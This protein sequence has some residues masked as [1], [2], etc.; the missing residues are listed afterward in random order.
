MPKK[1]IRLIIFVILIT[2]SM[3]NIAYAQVPSKPL[4]YGPKISALQN[5]EDI[6]N[7]LEQLKTIRANLI[8]INVKADTPA[9]ELKAID[10]DL[11]RYIDQLRIIRGNLVN[12][13]DKYANS[14]SDVFFAEQIVIIANCY[15]VSL[16]HQQLLIRALQNNVTE[17]STLFY[18]TYMIPIYYYI[19][20]GDEQIAY[21]QTYIVVS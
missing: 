11:Q 18:S 5:K 8:V 2:V 14:I 10:T 9:E 17:A 6:L 20:L 13:A 12:H 16:K 21:T 7:N 19:T 4:P 15:I 3:S 1:L